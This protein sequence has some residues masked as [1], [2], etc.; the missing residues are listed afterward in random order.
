MKILSLRHRIG[1]A[2][3]VFLVFTRFTINV[4]CCVGLTLQKFNYHSS[5]IMQ[6][7]AS[8]SAS[9]SAFC[10]R[11]TRH[12]L[13]PLTIDSNESIANESLLPPD[14]YS[15][16]P[17]EGVSADDDIVRHDNLSSEGVS[18]NDSDV[19]TINKPPQELEPSQY[20][21]LA[22][23]LFASVSSRGRVRAMTPAKRHII[24][25]ASE[26][27]SKFALNFDSSPQDNGFHQCLHQRLQSSATI[28]A[29]SCQS[30]YSIGHL[31]HS[32][33]IGS[34][35]IQPCVPPQQCY[36]YF[37]DH[38]HCQ[39]YFKSILPSSKL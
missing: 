32:A 34:N 25:P 21:P 1:I 29:S 17:S 16:Q 14:D 22:S 38:V 8:A 26:D 36:H 11:A 24:M 12:G 2:T 13:S 27:Q 15:K 30:T 19:Q 18:A 28:S 23:N 35:H 6:A 31:R 20:S 9:A 39:F 10:P 3:Q 33:I 4:G 7:S 5:T 37:R